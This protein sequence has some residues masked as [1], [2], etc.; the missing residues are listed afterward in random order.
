VDSGRRCGGFS[1]VATPKSRAESVVAVMA[2][3]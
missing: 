1:P 2:V 3:S